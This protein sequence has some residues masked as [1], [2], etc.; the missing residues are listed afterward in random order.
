M[1]YPKLPSE[2]AE[3]NEQLRDY[4]G[5]DTITG[6]VIWRIAWSNDQ[7]EMRE[8]DCTPEGLQLLTPEVR[9]LPKYQWIRNRWILERLVAVPEFQQKELAGRKISYE[10]VWKFEDRDEQPVPP[11]FTACKF[12]IDTIYAAQGLQPFPKYI[13]PESKE[14]IE[15][16]KKRVDDLVEQLFGDES[17]LMM[18]TVT[19]EAV[20]I[21]DTKM[22]ES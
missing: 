22:K 8:T 21:N 11:I 4:F 5:V 19:G 17:G 12:I 1:D 7:Y 6:D 15:E 18:R 14:P 3:L 10:C 2:I 16:Q 9:L 20:V 13:D